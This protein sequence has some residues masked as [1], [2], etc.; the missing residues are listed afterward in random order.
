MKTEEKEREA[1]RI[2]D[3]NLSVVNTFSH[4]KSHT[5]FHVMWDSL[6]LM[7]LTSL[8]GRFFVRGVFLQLLFCPKHMFVK[9]IYMISVINGDLPDKKVQPY[10]DRNVHRS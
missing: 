6:N 10:Q 7:P 2:P 3:Q 9:F 1:K 4:K 8:S 5:T